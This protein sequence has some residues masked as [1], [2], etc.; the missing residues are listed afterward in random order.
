MPPCGMVNDIT[1]NGG[2]CEAVR[3]SAD[4]L[5]CKHEVAE[6]LKVTDRTID[7]WMKEGLIP[8]FKIGRNVRF[9]IP[10]VLDHLRRN[11]LVG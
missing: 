10:D 11:H 1:L 2:G 3:T 5:C 7:N 4:S 9:R 8:Y 6:Y